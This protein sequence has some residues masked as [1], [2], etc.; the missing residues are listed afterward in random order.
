MVGG[1]ITTP[2]HVKEISNSGAA[3]IVIGSLLENLDN[4]NLIDEMTS[5]I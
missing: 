2:S 3:Y 5:A 1:G 4:A